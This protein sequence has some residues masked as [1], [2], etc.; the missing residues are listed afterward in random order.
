MYLIKKPEP[1][2]LAKFEADYL[3]GTT[4]Y[5][6][7]RDVTFC[8]RCLYSNQKPNSEREYTH[9]VDSKKPTVEL[10]KGGICAA[11]VIAERKV[12]VDWESR[13]KELVELCD[14]FRKNNG[15]YDCIIP[16]SG[17]KDSAYTAHILKHK[18]RMNPLTVTWAPHI[19]TDWGWRNMQA[20][21]NSGFDNYL[22]TPDGRVRRLLTRL[23][24]EN[25]LHPFQ[26]FIMGQ[27]YFPPKI[28]AKLGIPLIFYGE[29]PV[30]YGNS[31]KE[32]G[33][34]KKD[35]KYFTS[36]DKEA[37]YISG[38][39]FKQLVEDWGIK[40]VDLEPYTPL[41]IEEASKTSVEVQYLGYYLKWHPQ[42]CYYYA[43]ENTGFKA[44]PER[45]VGTYSKYSSIDD[46]IDDFHYYT[47]YVKFGI[48]RTTY[49]ASQEIR[50]GDI[51]RA[52]GLAL[53]RKYDGEYPERFMD[54]LLA[55]LSIPAKEFP[56]QSKLFE[57]PIMDREYFNSLC[58][59]F[60]SPHLW[61]RTESGWRL[62]K[63][64]FDETTR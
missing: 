8:V 57:Q 19:Y 16:G 28:A 9:N 40:R 25:I 30:E 56:Q 63:A 7:P 26:P 18:Y 11:C 60:R 32:A 37:G 3:A 61:R 45:T 59:R 52:E 29:N 14:R 46:K 15:E 17:G 62:R 42:T 41:S 47:T 36:T 49:D 4:K 43:A 23:S 20:W 33:S 6:L 51:D 1:I 2:D 13:E 21:I 53:A 64:A 35:L 12:E 48:G 24:M 44:A 58:D 10:D 38:I 27:M 54:E 22:Y 34:P 39:P 31:M 50:N 55:Y 5:G